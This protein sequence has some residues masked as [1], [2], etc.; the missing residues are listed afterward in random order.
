MKLPFSRICFFA[1][2]FLTGLLTTLGVQS[3]LRHHQPNHKS[4]AVYVGPGEQWADAWDVA[5]GMQLENYARTS[6]GVTFTDPNTGLY[7]EIPLLAN[8]WHGTT[9][10]GEI[11]PDGSAIV[12]RHDKGLI[13]SA[14]L[15]QLKPTPFDT[16]P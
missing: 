10:V 11:L 12:I 2:G 15:C 4:F 7:R 8:I 5:S 14:C 9:I 16:A 1:A 6:F 3:I 13:K